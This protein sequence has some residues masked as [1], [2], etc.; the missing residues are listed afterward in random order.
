MLRIQD[1]LVSCVRLALWPYGI[2]NSRDKQLGENVTYMG[3]KCHN[4]DYNFN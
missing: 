3:D 1:M 2:F 4:T